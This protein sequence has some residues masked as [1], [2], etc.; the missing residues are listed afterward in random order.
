ME[1]RSDGSGHS[2]AKIILIGEHSV[3]YGQ[4]AIALP[5][6]A[7]QAQAQLFFTTDHKQIIN[8][9][10]FDGSLTEM[11]E[12]MAG[13]T[14]LIN[15]ILHEQH[16]ENTGFVLTIKSQLPAERGMG[17][18]AAVAI[19]IIRCF[20]DAFNLKL[21]HSQTLRLADI[22]ETDTHKNPSG[23]DAATT[24]SEKPIWLIRG[25]A[26]TPL[27]INMDGY[28]LICDSGIKGQT[29]K[30]IQ[31]VK[32][33][34]TNDPQATQKQIAT[35][36]N[37]TQLVREQLAHND[38]SGLGQSLTTAQAQLTALGVSTS[39]LNH[40]ISLALNNGALGSK[41]TGGG[42]GGCFINLTKDLA[43][44]EKLAVLLKGHG[45]TQSWIQPL[46]SKTG[47]L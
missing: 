17:S 47:G 10:Y 26:P 28:L 2:H 44:A 24:A 12:Q 43:T 4:P 37:L 13:L 32:N 14:H 11:P 38:L 8:S 27:P 22:S 46:S 1:R 3:V 42:C 29:S 41:L 39:S 21:T 34:L 45:V 31:L 23:L 18:S 36:G 9:S 5:L 7:I 33:H 19:A 15:T 40:L 20:Y 6:T 16:R 35:L 30:A 25:Q